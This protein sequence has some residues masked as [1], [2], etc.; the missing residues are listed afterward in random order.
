M[1]RWAIHFCVATL[2]C[3]SARAAWDDFNRPDGPMGPNWT[4]VVGTWRIENNQARCSPH[5]TTFDLT[6]FN[7][8]QAADVTVQ[9]DVYYFGVAGSMTYAA[10]VSAYKD[11]ANNVFISVVDD[12]WLGNFNRVYFYY[13]NMGA[14]WPGMTGG[15]FY[16]DVT[17]FIEA[18]IWTV[19][20]GNRITLNIDRDMNGVPEDVITRGN[21]PLANLGF[22]VGLGG[23]D[24]AT[25]DN[26]V[27]TPEP[28]SLVILAAALLRG[29]R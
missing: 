10:L 21:I 19:M 3:A 28:A 8:F 9:A 1:H 2:G 15:P 25:F 29:R 22:G 23:N 16:L 24:N 4:T 11:P 6:T 18:R 14:P 7:P 5:S 13:G 17:S 12:K 27:V 26:F 20:A